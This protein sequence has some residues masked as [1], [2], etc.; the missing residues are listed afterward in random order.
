MIE[1]LFRR[2]VMHGVR[3]VPEPQIGFRQRLMQRLGG[4]HRHQALLVRA[5]EDGW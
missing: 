2:N 3:N 5:S 1:Q 4:G